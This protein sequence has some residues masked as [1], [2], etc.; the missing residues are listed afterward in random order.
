MIKIF[1]HPRSG[2]HFL[3]AFVA[4]NFYPNRDLSVKDLTWGH[5]SNRK[6]KEL[7]PYGQLFGGHHF[8]KR[9]FRLKPKPLLYIYRD[10]R[11]VAYSIWK[12]PN[13]LNREMSGLSFSEFLRT[14]LDWKGSPGNKIGEGL[15]IFEHWSKHVEEWS[16]LKG[17]IVLISYEELLENPGKVYKKILLHCFPM[18]Y[19]KKFNNTDIKII[20]K[21]LGLLPNKGSKDSWKKVFNEDDLKYYQNFISK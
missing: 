15:T 1:S 3:E 20:E 19:Y 2:T 17:N 4:N 13:F 5:W 7:N 8:P 16:R 14:P 10:G 12:T 18:Q 21:P 9:S 11:A 6:T